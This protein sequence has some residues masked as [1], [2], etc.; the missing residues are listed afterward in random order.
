MN[1]FKSRHLSLILMLAMTLTLIVLAGVTASAADKVTVTTIKELSNAL[2]E[3]GDC[4]I[5]IGV[6]ITEKTEDNSNPMTVVNGNKTINLNNHV[7][8]LT[9]N[10]SSASQMYAQIPNGSKLTINGV[11]VIKLDGYITRDARILFL[12]SDGGYLRINSGTFDSGRIKYTAVGG[13]AADK[14]EYIAGTI[15]YAHSGGVIDIYG[16]NFSGGFYAVNGSRYCAPVMCDKG[17]K[18]TIYDGT[19][20]GKSDSYAIAANEGDVKIYKGKFENETSDQ[21]AIRDSG[22]R[23]KMIDSTASSVTFSDKTLE[24]SSKVTVTDR[25]LAIETAALK[26]AKSGQ[27]YSDSLKIKSGAAPFKWAVIEGNLPYGIKLNEN[28]ELSGTAYCEA[29]DVAFTVQVTDALGKT[30]KRSYNL[31][32]TNDVPNDASSQTLNL[33]KGQKFA[34]TIES[35]NH[36]C[37]PHSFDLVSGTLP[38]GVEWNWGAPGG[39]I[40]GTPT[41]NGVYTLQYK[42]VR[43][44]DYSVCYHTLVLNIS[45]TGVN[46][47]DNTGDNPGDNSGEEPVDSYVFPFKDVKST[48]WFY[49]SVKGAHKMGLIDGMTADTFVPDG[50]LTYAQA[51]KL[52]ACMNQRYN[53]GKVTLTNGSANWYD[54]YV[55]YCMNK[56]IITQNYASVINN[57]IDRQSYAAIFAKCLPAKALKAKND[58]PDGSI[59]DVDKSNSNYNAIYTLYKAG[60][61]NGSDA[62]GSFKPNDNIKRSEVSA[63][64]SRMMDESARV[65][66]PAELAK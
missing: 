8:D 36:S 20:T 51:I 54:T 59:P 41:K 24:S 23:E 57:K 45:D 27:K 38:E 4:E 42:V 26:N 56:G 55:E 40:F 34:E 17:G 16:G 61:V 21:Y 32:I 60:I 14:V 43:R 19:F 58:I 50:N 29:Q 48:D 33:K 3:P 6:D 62:K 12:V 18:I 7:I 2:S 31:R 10:G 13:L 25:A 47:G 37:E 44:D 28:G 39:K 63:I 1:K 22:V 49:E 64:L 30:A 66:A 65:G 46:P 9:M 5:V 53:D 11:G 35:D 52:A 15:A